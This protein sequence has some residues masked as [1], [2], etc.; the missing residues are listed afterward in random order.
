MFANLHFTPSFLSFSVQMVLQLLP[1]QTWA[2]TSTTILL[3]NILQPILIGFSVLIHS[4]D[5]SRLAGWVAG[6][7]IVLQQDFKFMP[8][9]SVPTQPY[10]NNRG[11]RQKHTH[12]S[13]GLGPLDRCLIKGVLEATPDT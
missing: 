3:I 5:A 1:P 6:K 13:S 9:F 2:Y 7:T 10:I 12:R 8:I 11:C 4:M